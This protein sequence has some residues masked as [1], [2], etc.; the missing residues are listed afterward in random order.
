MGRIGLSV[1]I[2]AV[3]FLYLPLVVLTVFSFNDSALMAFP[4]SGFTLEWYRELAQNN[5][6]LKGFVTSF[7]IAQPVGILAHDAA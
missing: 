3:G 4:L 1:L 7:L 2:A 6:F 5:N